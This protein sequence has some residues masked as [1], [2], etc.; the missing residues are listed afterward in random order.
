M[1]MNTIKHIP[2]KIYSEAEKSGQK[3]KKCHTWP[4]TANITISLL[5]IQG[6]TWNKLQ[7]NLEFWHVKN[8][9][10]ILFY[11]SIET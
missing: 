7:Q 8:K 2:A 11:L 10:I 4:L 3:I 6:F 5:L 1:K 9:V